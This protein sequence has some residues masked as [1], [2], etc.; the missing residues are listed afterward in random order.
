MHYEYRLYRIK[1]NK[2]Q[3]HFT[4]KFTFH[5]HSYTFQLT[6]PQPQPFF[7]LWKTK[8]REVKKKR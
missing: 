2:T 5:K 1:Q 3:K 6:S 8:K 7:L 4:I